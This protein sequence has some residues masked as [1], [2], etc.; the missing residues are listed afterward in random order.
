[1]SFSDTSVAKPDSTFEDVMSGFAG[2]SDTLSRSEAAEALRRHALAGDTRAMNILASM[3]YEGIHFP[4]DWDKTMEWHLRAAE[5]GSV[6][7][8]VAVAMLLEEWTEGGPEEKLMAASKWYR[9]AAELGD[10]QSQYNVAIMYFAGVGV[11]EDVLTAIN[12]IKKSAEGGSAEAEYDLAAFIL[13]GE[14]VEESPREAYHWLVKSML[15]GH[16]GAALQLGLM[17]WGG[18]LGFE[19]QGQS[20]AL[21]QFADQ[22]GH[23]KAALFSLER[24][25][26]L[27]GEDLVNAEKLLTYLQRV[28][29]IE[30][31][32]AGLTRELSTLRLPD[33]VPPVPSERA[34]L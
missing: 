4:R 2:K 29:T 27:S 23:P 12:W 25:K 10:A 21:L 1:M 7:G 5:D 28:T 22:L 6:D 34:T 15:Q 31:P 19:D 13:G 30:D 17:L 24:K 14:L 20:L 8:M 11:E 26:Q 16:D 3:Y 32:P 33:Q 9:Q 18:F